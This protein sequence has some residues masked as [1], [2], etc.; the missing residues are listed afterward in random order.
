MKDEYCEKEIKNIIF[1][2]LDSKD[3]EVF[4]FGS[5]ASKEA[6]KF[7]DYDIGIIGKEIIPSHKK[8]MIEEDLEES[9]IPY[10]VD[11]VDFSLVSPEF[12]CIALSNTK[13]I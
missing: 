7:S 13:K 4:I 12:K 8:A 2:F 1:K 9:N 10:R 5:R 3:Y 6:K 11:I